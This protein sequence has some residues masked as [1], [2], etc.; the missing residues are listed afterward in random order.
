MDKFY[1][2]R[3]RIDV[4]NNKLL[5]PPVNFDSCNAI[6]K[7]VVDFINKYNSSNCFLYEGN[8][9]FYIVYH[10]VRNLYSGNE[11]FFGQ[12][13][14][15]KKC[16]N[17]DTKL[18]IIHLTLF[19]IFEPPSFFVDN[20]SV[21]LPEVKRYKKIIDSSIWNYYVPIFATD[22]MKNCTTIINYKMFH[23]VLQEVAC[24]TEKGL[25]N[26][27]VA[28]EYADLNARLL[29]QSHL[30]G[31]H[32]A[33][34]PFIFHSE[35]ELQTLI[36]EEFEERVEFEKESTISQIKKNKW[37]ILLVDDK[38]DGN[39]SIIDKKGTDNTKKDSYG[40]VLNSKLSIIVS[41][42]EKLFV[43]SNHKIGF[44]EGSLNSDK[45]LFSFEYVKNVSEAQQRIRTKK[46]DLILL[47]YLLEQDENNLKYGY[48]LL[49]EVYKEVELIK[50]LN[51][52]L[53]VLLKKPFSPYACEII[54]KLIGHSDRSV[55]L[56]YKKPYSTIVK[57]IFTDSQSKAL[58]DLY[59][60]Y[61]QPKINGSTN[62]LAQDEWGNIYKNVLSDKELGVFIGRGE[63]INAIERLIEKLSNDC[64]KIG[65]RKRLFFMFISAYSYAVHDRLLAE[66]LNPSEKYWF[67]STGA[68][69]T[70]TPQLFLYNLLKLMD[71]RLEDSGISK[72][73]SDAIYKL[74]NKIYQSK[75]KDPKGESVRKRA[76]T[77]YQDVL[78][79][80]YHYRSILKDV[81]IPFGQNANVFDTK[82][83]VLMTNFI[84]KKINLGGM[85][86]HLTQ[87]VHLT[88]FGT[89]RQWPEMWEEYIYFK[90]MFEKQL[91]DVDENKFRDLCDYIENY[92]L[93]LKS[94]QQ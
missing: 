62:N 52:I 53:E 46:Y 33:I 92:I 73:S 88:A 1:G 23:H 5:P 78:S 90:A 63:I 17:E 87:L 4:R 85:L 15:E 55:K 64:Y 25:Y 20:K 16:G 58:K 56:L 21:K 59:S 28:D 77:F 24:N 2:E 41:L 38:A 3:I 26:L 51:N 72:L 42:L 80:Q 6:H 32:K 84:Q 29:E 39:M 22:S 45:V 81:E 7:C 61:I 10:S 76:N 65:P 14:L 37:R 68:C 91:D 54:S 40:F 35:N 13:C 31:S 19:D 36:R 60:S 74:V 93:K 75:E 30:K 47:D 89:V 82:G 67:I 34:S 12:D 11:Y 69:P 43:D 18:P 70:N 71:K 27:S 49:E 9:S 44:G 83:S 94:Q 79:L 8:F 48:E 50:L 57:S 66:G 86:E